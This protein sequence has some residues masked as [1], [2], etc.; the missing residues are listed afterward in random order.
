[1]G[2]YRGQRGVVFVVDFERTSRPRNLAF[3]NISHYVRG[4]L[5]EFV[6]IVGRKVRVSIVSGRSALYTERVLMTRP[7][8]CFAVV[9]A[10]WWA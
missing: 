7:L 6:D 1:M 4:D 9:V 5:V 3:F 8:A 2:R 10:T